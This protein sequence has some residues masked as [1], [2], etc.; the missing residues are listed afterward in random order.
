MC[1]LPPVSRVFFQGLAPPR[2]RDGDG[3]DAFK[4]NK[5]MLIPGPPESKSGAAA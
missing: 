1:A 2:R 4:T 3:I 5:N